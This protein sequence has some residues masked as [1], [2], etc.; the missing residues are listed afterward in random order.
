LICFLSACGFCDKKYFV[1][2]LLDKIPESVKF[3]EIF[4]LLGGSV[5]QENKNEQTKRKKKKMNDLRIFL[6][7]GTINQ[8]S[9]L[10]NR[11]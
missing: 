10:K 5:L 8:K 4:N 3:L 9:A 11:T 6:K 7:F 2:C 1:S